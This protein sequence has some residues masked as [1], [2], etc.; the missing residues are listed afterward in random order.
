MPSIPKSLSE[1]ERACQVAEV[2]WK[3][4]QNTAKELKGVFD[5]A[6]ATLRKMIVEESDPGIFRGVEQGE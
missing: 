2:E 4:A 6:V 1:Q 3:A 5:T